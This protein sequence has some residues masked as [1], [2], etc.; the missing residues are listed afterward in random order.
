MRPAPERAQAPPH[1]RGLAEAGATAVLADHRRRHPVLLDQLYGLCVVARRD[2]DL[3]AS[4]TQSLDQRPEDE[5]MRARRHVD[6]YSHRATTCSSATSRLTPSTCR[7]YQ[8]VNASSPQSCRDR[9]W[10][11]E[12]CSSMTRSTAAGCST[13]WRRSVDAASV[14]RANGSSSPR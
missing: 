9:S 8:S 5:R 6:P 10:R 3:V 12:T 1:L 13:P 2:L 4:C 14:S 11:P 7:S